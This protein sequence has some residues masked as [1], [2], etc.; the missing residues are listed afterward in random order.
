[1]FPSYLFIFLVPPTIAS[2]NQGKVSIFIEANGNPQTLVAV[3]MARFLQLPS[4][5]PGV[6][7][8]LLGGSHNQ[9]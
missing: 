9:R 6:N 3:Q 5:K 2:K 4:I 7:R 8:E 1:M